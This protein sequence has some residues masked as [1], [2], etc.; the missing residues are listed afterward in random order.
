MSLHEYYAHHHKG[1]VA[2]A[3]DEPAVL[4]EIAGKP[5]ENNRFLRFSPG[6]R[7]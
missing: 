2:G 1:M 6:L 7:G 3:E 4:S 5:T